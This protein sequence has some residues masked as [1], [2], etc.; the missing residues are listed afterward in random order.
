MNCTAPESGSCWPV[1]MRSRV[2]LPVPLRPTRPSFCRHSSLKLACRKSRSGPNDLVRFWITRR[3]M[4][5]WAIWCS[6]FGVQVFRCLVLWMLGWVV[7]PDLFGRYDYESAGQERLAGES[8]RR[9]ARGGGGEPRFL[10]GLHG[11]KPLSATLDADVAGR[12]RAVAAAL[13]RQVHAVIDCGVQY[14]IACARSY[15]KALRQEGDACWLAIHRIDCTRVGGWA[16]G[17]RCSVLRC[18]VFAYSVF[19]CWVFGCWCGLGLWVGTGAGCGWRGYGQR[20][21]QSTIRSAGETR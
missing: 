3:L 11:R 12:A 2:V 15:G 19:R 16:L 8:G 9:R 6:V 13:V 20:A 18:S 10:H 14:R 4:G 5:S 7:L 17:A 1:R 21:V